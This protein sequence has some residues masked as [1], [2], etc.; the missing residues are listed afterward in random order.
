MNYL[1]DI[2]TNQFSFNPEYVKGVKK[3]MDT[4]SSLKQQQD[5]FLL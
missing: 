2:L 3:Y 5:K 1:F 4:I